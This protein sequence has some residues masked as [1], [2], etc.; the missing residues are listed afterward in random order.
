MAVKKTK[1]GDSTEISIP[2]DANRDVGVFLLFLAVFA[3]LPIYALSMR[4]VFETTEYDWNV[5]GLL[6]LGIGLLGASLV[7]FS[8][9]KISVSQTNITVKDGL[10]KA[11]MR[12]GWSEEPAVRL[13]SIEEDRGG[14]QVEVWL[15]NLVD[16]KNQYTLDQRVGQQMASR[17]LAEMVAKTINCPVIE[18]V[19]GK[20]VRIER[21]ELDLPFVERVH[22]HPVLLGPEVDKPGECAVEESLSGERLEFRWRLWSAQLVCQVGVFFAILFGFSLLP[23]GKSTGNRSLLDLARLDGEYL[24]FYALAALFAIALVMLAGY[25]VVL[26]ADRQQVSVRASVFG[27][28]VRGQNIPVTELE[29]IAVRNSAQ[30]A[31]LQFISDALIITQR[32]DDLEAG[33]WVASLTRRFYA[34]KRSGADL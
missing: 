27:V 12:F 22:R 7:L 5:G 3:V 21:S 14:R 32:L 10:F 25:L 23:L 6:A 13:Y 18:K 8:H 34:E 31:F 16:G 2:T 20:D 11:R 28:P 15:V 4:L 17:T 24:Y 9:K 33:R 30:G 1:R 19:G 26:V 29:D